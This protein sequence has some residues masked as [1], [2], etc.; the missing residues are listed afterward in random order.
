MNNNFSGKANM[1]IFFLT[2]I[3]SV[4]ACKDNPAAAQQKNNTV[5][6][7]KA[8]ATD[9]HTAVVTGNINA[10][11]QH[12]AA[13]SDLNQKDALGG[14]SPLI[15]ACLFEQKEIAMLL[16]NAGASINFQNNDGSTALHVASFF[17]KPDMVKL[18][19]ANKVDKTV[20]N[21]YKNTAYE[22]VTAPFSTVKSIYEQMKQ[23]L[24]PMGVKL[25]LTYIEKTRPVIAKMLQ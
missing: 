24:E 13:G 21:K 2:I 6:T 12:I 3:V 7:Q 1:Y 23:M 17:C 10:V 16:I 14:S 15:T 18:L 20:K 11:K 8:P 22:T 9:L 19:L 25:D 5:K 4:M